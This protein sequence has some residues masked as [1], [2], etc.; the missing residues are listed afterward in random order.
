MKHDRLR[1][2]LLLAGIALAVPALAQTFDGEVRKIDKA[3]QKISLAHGDIK[4]LDLPAMTLAYRVKDPAWL[5]VVQ[6]GDKV[7]FSAERINGQL[8]LTA[9]RKR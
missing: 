5:D 6:T 4:S 7:K 2:A 9:I 1:Q 8:M 3:Q